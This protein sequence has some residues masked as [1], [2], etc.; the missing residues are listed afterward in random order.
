MT[1]QLSNTDARKQRIT[2]N[3]D[4]LPKRFFKDIMPEGDAK[5]LVV[6]KEQ[7]EAAKPEY[8]QLREWNNNGI[9]TETK[10]KK[11]GVTKSLYL[12]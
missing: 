5:G 11:L 4:T 10:L 8:Y 12:L 6:S 9:P 2:A 3:D 7:F 1:N